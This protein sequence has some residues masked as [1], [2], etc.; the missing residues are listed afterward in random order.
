MFKIIL[1]DDLVIYKNG[2]QV[3]L[4]NLKRMIGTS[5]LAYLPASK[6]MNNK[7]LLVGDDPIFSF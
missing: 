1:I 6:M 5:P 3:C 7:N 2:T 4:N